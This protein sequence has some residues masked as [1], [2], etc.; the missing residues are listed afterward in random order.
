MGIEIGVWELSF[1]LLCCLLFSLFPV[2]GLAGFGTVE[3]LWVAILHILNVPEGDA[4]TTGF[5]LHIIVVVFCIIMG[6]Y[7]A[8]SLKFTRFPTGFKDV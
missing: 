1:A 4:I 5:G 8:M 3:A 6:I 7:G 2:H